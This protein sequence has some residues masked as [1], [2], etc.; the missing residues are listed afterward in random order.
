MINL[1]NISLVT[2]EEKTNSED[3]RANEIK[4][5]CVVKKWITPIVPESGD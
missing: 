5:K 3:L 1:Y 4:S 2:T